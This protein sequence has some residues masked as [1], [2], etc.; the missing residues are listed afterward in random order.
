MNEYSG[1]L[2]LENSQNFDYLGASSG[3]GAGIA[4]LFSKLGAKLVIHG[5]NEQGLNSTIEKC[6]ES[7]SK[8]VL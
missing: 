2:E 1:K 5:R 3:I 4:I 7:S 6:D 8:N